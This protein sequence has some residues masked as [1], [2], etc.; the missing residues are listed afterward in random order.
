MADY[1]ASLD[2]SAF[3]CDYDYNTPSAEHLEKTHEKLFMKVRM[4]HPDLPIIL[5]T[6]PKPIYT[7]GEDLDCLEVI[8]KT[9]ENALARGDKKVSF[10]D[11]RTMFA[12]AGTEGTVDSV[13]PTDLGFYFMAKALEPTLKEIAKKY[14]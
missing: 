9:Y 2:M 5:V 12:L 10:I 14:K 6:R 4:A 1:I 7:K 8:R 13:H 3:V 11:G